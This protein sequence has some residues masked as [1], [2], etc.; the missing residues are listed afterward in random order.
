MNYTELKTAIQEYAENTETTFVSNLDTFIR[1]AEERINHSL[2][3]P[4][5][6]KN[7]T[8][9]T[10]AS[11][12]YLALP[13]D[14]LA[15]FSLASIVAGVH[16]Y[17]LYKDVA[18]LR[19]AFPLAATEGTPR[20]YAQWDDDTLLLAPT[21]NANLTMELH[22]FADPPSIVTST[23]S[24][25]GDNAESMLLY[26]CL[27]EAYTFM[28][29]EPDLIE[30]YDTRYKEALDRFKDLGEARSRKDAFREIELMRPPT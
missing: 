16:D 3:L 13:P 24:W 18:F 27:V 30:L 8:G 23:T 10:T 2:R 12:P 4:D 7:S 19:E 22:Y 5:F 29:G 1:Q 9:T 11:N 15:S 14:Y 26:G 20:F 25:V 28:K 6:K 17:L 21:P